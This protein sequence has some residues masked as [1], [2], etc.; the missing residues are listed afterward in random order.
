MILKNLYGS[1]EG[2]AKVIKESE[3]I[4]ANEEK[5]IRLKGWKAIAEINRKANKIN[6]E[7]E[8][9]K[10]KAQLK[11]Y[12]KRQIREVNRPEREEKAVSARASSERR[13]R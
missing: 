3:R 9:A 2:M 10:L 4:M 8:M 6:A 5:E 1:I 11:E 13:R 7:N 12:A